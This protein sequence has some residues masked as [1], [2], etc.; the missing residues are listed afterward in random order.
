MLEPLVSVAVLG[1]LVNLAL[2]DL[3]DPLVLLVLDPLVYLA[4]LVLLEQE[5]NLGQLVQQ[6]HLV[7]PRDV[8]LV[9]TN[10]K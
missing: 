5:V 6:V 4:L 7:K 8:L 10:V 2:L 9:P 3:L 1:H